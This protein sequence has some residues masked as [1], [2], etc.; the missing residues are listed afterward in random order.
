MVGG[1]VAPRLDRGLRVSLGRSTPSGSGTPVL[2]L[3]G[4]GKAEIV[5][6]RAQGSSALMTS[7]GSGETKTAA[8]GAYLTRVL[9]VRLGQ[10]GGWLSVSSD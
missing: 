2:T 7:W 6:D 3:P 1:P 5:P 10:D 8:R 4:S 9:S